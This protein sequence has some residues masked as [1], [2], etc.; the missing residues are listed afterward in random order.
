MT[1]VASFALLAAQVIAWEC[2]FGS[3]DQRV[4]QRLEKECLRDGRQP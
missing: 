3:C 2:A 4:L 1:F